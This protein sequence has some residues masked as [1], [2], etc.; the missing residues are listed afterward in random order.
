MLVLLSP[1]WQGSASAGRP[2]EFA[3]ASGAQE[4]PPADRGEKPRG[5]RELIGQAAMQRK[6]DLRLIGGL[7]THRMWQGE[8]E[9]SAEQQGVIKK[10]NRLLCEARYQRR[11]TDAAA[12][13]ADEAARAEFLARSWERQLEAIR[14]GIR[15]VSLGVLTEEQAAFVTQRDLG[16][17]GLSS[18]YA[19]NNV[20]EILGLSGKTSRTT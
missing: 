20:V 4:E 1:V 9:L 17:S 11:L 7:I 12:V 3:T 2:C 10:L 15:L 14:H 19:D 16:F 5:D 8:L 13:P 18:L 6:T